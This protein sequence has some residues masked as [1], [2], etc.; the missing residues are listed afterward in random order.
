MHIEVFYVSP[1]LCQAIGFIKKIPLDKEVRSCWYMGN[2]TFPS[3]PLTA[4]KNIADDA[5]NTM[6]K[7]QGVFI[8]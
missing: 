8:K 4:G 1:L 3:I 2:T 6:R 7:H 5:W